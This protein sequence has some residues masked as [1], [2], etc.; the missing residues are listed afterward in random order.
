[1][2]ITHA[3][4]EHLDANAYIRLLVPLTAMDQALA[5]QELRAALLISTR[6]VDACVNCAFPRRIKL[7]TNVTQLR[8]RSSLSAVSLAFGSPRVKFAAS[9]DQASSV[10]QRAAYHSRQ[11]ATQAIYSPHQSAISNS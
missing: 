8:D 1:M 2:R 9:L 10:L 5:A 3:S 6:H 11:R 4:A 7:G